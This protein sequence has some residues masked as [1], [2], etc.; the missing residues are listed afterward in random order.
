VG[1]IYNTGKTTNNNIIN[2]NGGVASF[3][4]GGDNNSTIYVDVDA[5]LT[6]G[7]T[8][9]LGVGSQIT[10]RGNVTLNA[11]QTNLNVSQTTLSDD[12]TFTFNGG[13]LNYTGNLSLEKYDFIT[14]IRGRGLRFSIEH[15]IK[16]Q[17]EFGKKFEEF[18]K[19]HY[20]VLFNAKWHRICV[21]PPLII[22][23]EEIEI[24]AQAAISTFKLLAKDFT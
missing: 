21:T 18:A 10:G 8:F 3:T 19:N 4:G 20:N 11:G 23:Y 15:N 6:L 13:S 17:E 1:V 14:D 5:G 22:E 12:L 9:N 2:L 7:G 24:A 16:N